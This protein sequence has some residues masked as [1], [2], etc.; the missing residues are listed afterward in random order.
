MKNKLFRFAKMDVEIN[1]LCGLMVE[2]MHVSKRG[3]V[4]TFNFKKK[5]LFIFFLNL[6]R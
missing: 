3:L 2:F 5:F 6:F 1:Q 4:P